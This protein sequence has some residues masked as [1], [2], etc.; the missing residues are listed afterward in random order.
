[1]LLATQENSDTAITIKTVVVRKTPMFI[2]AAVKYKFMTTCNTASAFELLCNPVVSPFLWL[3][4]FVDKQIVRFSLT[5]YFV[6]QF[7]NFSA[8]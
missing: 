8:I 5:F 6:G 1:V 4:I 3:S 2:N 7:S